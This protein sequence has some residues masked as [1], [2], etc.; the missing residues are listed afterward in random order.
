MRAFSILGVC[1]LFALSACDTRENSENKQALTLWYEQPAQKWTEALPLGNG[2]IGAMVFGGTA[3]ERLQFN[4]ETLWTGEPREYHREGASAYLPEIRQLLF[5]GK[6][7]QAEALAERE[8]MGKKSHEEEYEGLVSK[9]LAKVRSFEGMTG[10]PSGPTYDDSGWDEMELPAED[11]WRDRGHEGLDGAV[12]FRTSFNLPEAWKGEDLVLALGRIRDQDFTYVNGRQVGTIHDRGAARKYKVDASL[13]KSGENVIAV[14]V[15]NYEDKGGFVGFKKDRETMALYPEGKEEN[16]I[17]LNKAWKYKIQDYSPPPYPEYMARYQPFGDLW[18]EFPGHREATGYRRQLDIASALLKTS[19]EVEGVRY[20]REYF[21]SAPD[22]V[23]AVHI[24]ASE[25]GALDFTASLTSPHPGFLTR[26]IDEK[27]LALSVDV[28]AGALRGESYLRIESR[29]GVVTLTDEALTVKE[30]TTATLY[31]T[32]GTNYINYRDISGDPEK[33]C[34]DA[35]EKVAGRTYEDIRKAHIQ[36]YQK[37]FNTFSINLGESKNDSLPTDKRIEA[38]ATSHDPAFVALHMQ[39]GRYLMLS[40]SRPGT[41][42]A[43]LQG[44]WNPLMSP[45]WDSK[46][47][48]NINVEMNYWPAE[49]LNLS[50][51]HEPLFDMISE[52]AE[53]GRN[54]ARAHYNARGWVLHHNTDL[55]RGTAPINASNHGIWVTGGAWLSHHLWEHYLF[56]RDSVFLRERAYPV[57]KEAARF[58]V[59]F[60]IEDPERGWLISTPSNSPETGGLVAGPT[61]DHQII[62]SLFKNCVAAAEALNTDAAF[63]DTLEA[64]YNK[65]APNQIGRHGQLQEWLEDIDD[66]ENKHRHVSHLWGLHPGKEI[67][68]RDTPELFD[69]ARQSLLFRGDAGTGWSLAWK[70]NFWARF[71]DG[72][73]AR[74][75]IKKMLSPVNESDSDRGGASYPNLF[76]AHPPFQIDGN[77]GG[78]A[79]VAEMLVQSHLGMIDVLPALP[80]DWATGEIK[81]LCARGG[82]ELTMQWEEGKLKRLEILSKA[83]EECSVRYGDLTVSFPTRKGGVYTLDETLKQL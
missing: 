39:Y 50:A 73:H 17:P 75:L 80:G 78:A 34:T 54:T 61:M 21:A 38:F 52:L 12:W 5:E 55:W 40:S 46:Y 26:K 77:F 9:W 2:R 15:I 82:F 37:Y 22:Q 70:I 56:T 48:C 42:P 83:G 20:T 24:T 45:P 32:A 69:A 4:E 41:R 74:K 62:R 10:N 7:D 23:I 33:A 51:C 65:I 81:G 68:W 44:I 79:G 71:K 27:T 72:D 31:L 8:F 3:R 29:D 66:P 53:N 47:T 25:P 11:G 1:L 13:L 49:V 76:D 28:R 60:L 57:M 19:Y 59:D 18:L 30:A 6:Q 64:K 58:F 63:R 14:Q 67:N 43:N 35:L 36:D 16:K